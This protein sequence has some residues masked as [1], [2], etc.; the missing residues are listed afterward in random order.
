MRHVGRKWLRQTALSPAMTRTAK[1]LL[2]DWVTV[3]MVHRMAVPELGIQ[4]LDPGYLSRCLD[5]LLDSGHHFISLEEAITRSQQNTLEKK[6]WVAFSLD[7]GFFEQLDIAA[8]IFHRYRCPATFFLITGFI[9]GTLWP[10][11]HQL[12]YVVDHTTQEKLRITIDGHSHELDPR[13]PNIHS[14][15][16]AIFKKTPGKDI[17][18]L[19]TEIGKAAGVEIPYP[20]PPELAPTSWERVR[21]M[22]Q[23]GMRFAA[24]SVSHRI[25]SRLDDSELAHE[26]SASIDRVEQLCRQPANLFCYPSG[27]SDEFDARAIAILKERQVLGA[28]SAEPGYLSAAQVR[29]ENASRYFIPRM[30]LPDNFDEFKRYMSWAQYIR[31]YIHAL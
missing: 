17:Y 10:W 11:D 13:S 12:M 6:Q 1:Q 31:E 9:D 8:E 3:F 2:P 27:R 24:H 14:A 30:T 26:I 19:V 5:Y 25:L 15:V 20:P 7:D 29:R 18:A 4:G 28:F 16:L 22:E 21:E 23:K